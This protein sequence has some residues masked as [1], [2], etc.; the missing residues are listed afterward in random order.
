M[1]RSL[2]YFRWAFWQ[3]C[4]I[5]IKYE[6]WSSISIIKKN[7]SFSV[8]KFFQIKTNRVEP[9]NRV[10]FCHWRVKCLNLPR[11]QLMLQWCFHDLCIRKNRKY[12]MQTVIFVNNQSKHSER[13][14]CHGDE[15]IFARGDII[16]LFIFI[17][18]I[19]LCVVVKNPFCTKAW[20][21]FR[22]YHF[23]C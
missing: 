16:K 13:N 21:Q 5:L 9:R 19:S 11:F 18:C 2:P 15:L 17:I 3:Y 22:Q 1:R 23:Y 12:L 10:Q 14:A 6:K 20:E 8:S 4:N 7:Y